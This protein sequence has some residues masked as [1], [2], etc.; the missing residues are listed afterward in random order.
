M[1]TKFSFEQLQTFPTEAEAKVFVLQTLC[2]RLPLSLAPYWQVGSSSQ[3]GPPTSYSLPNNKIR[4]EVDIT[5]LDVL[6][7]TKNK[8]N[9]H[10]YPPD[11]EHILHGFTSSLPPFMAR[12]IFGQHN[13]P[14]HA[15]ERVMGLVLTLIVKAGTCYM[16]T[17]EIHD[18]RHIR[19]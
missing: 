19:H 2:Q 8:I 17:L 18:I 15:R 14:L 4:E 12:V 3:G 5:P 1:R 6:T 11:T 13:H 7:H 10:V 9:T 16:T